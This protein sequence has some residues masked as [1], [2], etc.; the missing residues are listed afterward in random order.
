MKIAIFV[1][2]LTEDVFLTALLENYF[3]PGKIEISRVK[4]Q[5][6]TKRVYFRSLEQQSQYG[7]HFCLIVDVGSDEAVLS[8]LKESYQNMRKK[9]YS[10]FFG[11]RDLKSGQHDR[12]GQYFVR[13]TQE[14][15]DDFRVEHNVHFH[16]AKME[17]EAW[18][19][20]APGLMT[21]VHSRLTN[22]FVQS[23]T[24]INLDITDPEASIENPAVMIRR[25][26]R[27]VGLGI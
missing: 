8:K 12:F 4:H 14:I 22:E 5:G 15:V 23:I 13:K 16:F 7:E 21:R 17:I 1:E 26:F 19:F 25:I 20:A 10:A 3:N 18:F 2:G 27:T 9:G 6:H 24:G 11:L